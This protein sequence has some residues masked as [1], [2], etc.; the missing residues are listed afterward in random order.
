MFRW[1]ME[2]S[3][4]VEGA[5]FRSNLFAVC[6]AFIRLFLKKGEVHSIEVFSFISFYLPIIINNDEIAA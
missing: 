6:P 5:P 2:Y 3:F 1:I 4:I